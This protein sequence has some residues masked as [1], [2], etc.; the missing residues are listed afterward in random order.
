[1]K[2]NIQEGFADNNGIKIHYIAINTNTNEIPLLLV[3][4]MTNSANEI[5]EDLSEHNFERYTIHISIRGRGKS[6]SPESGYSFANQVS[7]INAVVNHL[8][9]KELYL[10]GHSVGSSF[11]IAYASQNENVKA[12]IMGDYPPFY[13]PFSEEWSKKVL[14]NEDRDISDKATIAIGKEAEVT[15]LLRELKELKCPRLMLRG[16]K[17]G[18]LFKAGDADYLGKVIPEIEMQVLEE[19][20][21]DLLE[22]SPKAFIKTVNNFIANI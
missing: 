6:Q 20:K 10:Y 3:P 14:A 2:T 18:S 1:M 17:E 13:P 16:G 22:P 19:S 21:H 12:L 7:D 5:V 9:I 4:G 11:A 15:N 8:K